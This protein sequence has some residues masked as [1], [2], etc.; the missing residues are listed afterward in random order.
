[1]KKVIFICIALLFTCL[2][3]AQKSSTATDLP[4][5]SFSW[6]DDSINN[7]LIEKT[8][9]LVPVRIGD[10]PQQFEAQLD[11]GAITTMVYENSIMPYIQGNDGIKQLIDTTQLIEYKG[12]KSP[13]IRGLGII[14]DTVSFSQ[15]DILL[16]KN[17]GRKTISGER[18]RIG[19][20]AA[21][22]FNDGVLIIDYSNKRFCKL[23]EL[24]VTMEKQFD[25]VDIEYIPERNWIFL[26][27]NIGDSQKKVLF[28]T[29]SSLFPLLTS[30]NN[31]D[32]IANLTQPVDTLS[33]GGWGKRIEVYGYEPKERVSLGKIVFPP[34]TVYASDYLKE[35]TEKSNSFWGV[36]GNRY[37][38]DRVVVIDYRN[39]RFGVSLK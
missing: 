11:L 4:W 22:L 17:Y 31:A 28:D 39:N 23:L 33:V 30:F 29:G 15:K 3:F 20:L 5:I 25:F 19:T 27:L 18:P 1:M 37:F 13:M 16:F 38:L 2:T 24:P 35:E 21:D 14:L 8:A 26:P 34:L 7:R 10:L 36:V 9:I 6:K 32:K 12:R